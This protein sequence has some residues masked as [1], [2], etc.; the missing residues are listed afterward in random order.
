MTIAANNMV[1]SVSLI[2]RRLI[3]TS[4]V[5]KKASG[6]STF[7]TSGPVLSITLKDPFQS[8]E[9]SLLSSGR[10]ARTG[11]GADEDTSTWASLSWLNP[12][13]LWSVGSTRPPLPEMMPSLKSC[14]GAIGYRYD[15]IR[16]LPS[17]LDGDALFETKAGLTLEVNPSYEVKSRRA[18]VICTLSDIKPGA[19]GGRWYGIAKVSSKAKH[20]VESIRA[21]YQTPYTCRRVAM[22]SLTLEPALDIDKMDPSITLLAESTSGRTNA[23]LRCNRKDPT[24]TLVHAIDERN[25][26]SP[27][28]SLPTGKITFNWEAELDSGSITARIDPASFIQ[29]KW[30]DHSLSGKWVLDATI[31][32][33]SAGGPIAADVRVRRQFVF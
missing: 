1:R 6:S 2:T 16:N 28:I 8:P 31:P 19:G 13:L 32:L 11:F 14:K 25:T 20:V 10:A 33:E 15:D 4:C 17:F 26:L 12:T 27:E 24:L 9:A 23:V 30:V 3:L 7:E 29:V 18:N 5:L 21:S 22:R